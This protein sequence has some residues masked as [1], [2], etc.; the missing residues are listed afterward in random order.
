MMKW[1]VFGGE[2]QIRK[3]ECIGSH[4][5]ECASL[6]DWEGMDFIDHHSFH[7]DMLA[8]QIWRLLS[9]HDTLCA[10]VLRP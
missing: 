8:K 2:I 4:G 9:N 10:C 6:R 5:E 1:L 3:E 7:V